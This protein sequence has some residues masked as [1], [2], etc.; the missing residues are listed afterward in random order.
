VIVT[1]SAAVAARINGQCLSALCS[2]DLFCINDFYCHAAFQLC[3]AAQQFLFGK[4]QPAGVKSTLLLLLCLIFLLPWIIISGKHIITST[5]EGCF[6]P[7]F[8]C[9]LATSVSNC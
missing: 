4:W 5:K 9:L 2:D 7:G 6:K 1:I 3:F 8:V